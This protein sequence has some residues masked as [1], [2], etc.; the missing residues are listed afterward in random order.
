MFTEV[1]GNETGLY[2]TTVK[3]GVRYGQAYETKDVDKAIQLFNRLVETYE[4]KGDFYVAR[5]GSD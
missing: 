3:N 5:Y 2:L 4:N 1:I